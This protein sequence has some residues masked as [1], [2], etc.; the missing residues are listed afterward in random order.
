V[1]EQVNITAITLS[2]LNAVDYGTLTTI[3][4]TIENARG[5]TVSGQVAFYANGAPVGVSL[6]A[7][8]STS[9]SLNLY[10]MGANIITAKYITSLDFNANDVVGP[11]T[12]T[13]NKATPVVTLT[14]LSPTKNSYDQIKQIS[15]DLGDVNLYSGNVTLL[16]NSTPIMDQV[17]IVAGNATINLLLRQDYVLTA[18]YNGNANYLSAVSQVLSLTT[19]NGT[20][21][22]NYSNL[23]YSAPRVNNIMK[24]EAEVILTT[25]AVNRSLLLNSGYV[26]FE[27]NGKVVNVYVSDGRATASFVSTN[28]TDYPGV[29]YFNDKHD[30]IVNG[31]KSG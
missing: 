18:R 26:R 19:T 7:N 4:A 2:A 17:P 23:M 29:D 28:T 1:K 16:H 31:I 25:S 8:N 11:K 12:V 10:V 9:L 21:T 3:N 14:D 22:T 27:L 24:I 15:V 5:F 20:I 6:L 13:V 30:G